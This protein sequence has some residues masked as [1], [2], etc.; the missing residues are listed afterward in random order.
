GLPLGLPTTIVGALTAVAASAAGRASPIAVVRG[1]PWSIIPLVAGLFV[2]VA[3]LQRTGI[4]DAL[5]ALLSAGGQAPTTAWAAG[6]AI[7]TGSN[8]INNL[9]AGL[10]ASL[11]VAK[12]HPPAAVKDALLIGVDLGPNI[13][14]TGSLATLL[15]LAAIRREGAH[16]G[17]WRFFRTGVLVT[18]PALVLALAAR[19][20]AP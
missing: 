17:A 14:V 1:A 12:A 2:L 11:A 18:A 5:A 4:I 13:S 19:L 9:P 6:A 7:A 16:I 10:V 3:G 8:L 20:A 15:W